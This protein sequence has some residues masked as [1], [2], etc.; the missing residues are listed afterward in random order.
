MKKKYN[1]NLKKKEKNRSFEAFPKLSTKKSYINCSQYIREIIKDKLVAF[2]EAKK[3]LIKNQHKFSSSRPC[4][5]NLLD[6]PMK[7]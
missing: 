7:Q 1:Q 2:L 4:M 6:F 5:T 3:L